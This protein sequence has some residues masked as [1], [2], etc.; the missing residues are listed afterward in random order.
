MK[1]VSGIPPDRTGGLGQRLLPLLD[2]NT[3]ERKRL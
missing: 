3:R 2:P 1:Q